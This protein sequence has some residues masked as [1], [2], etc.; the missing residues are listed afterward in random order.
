MILESTADLKKYVSVA[1]SFQ[2]PDIEPFIKKAA[3]QFTRPYVGELHVELK[4]EATGTDADL[5]NNARNHLR[6]ALTNF[7]FFLYS[8]YEAVLQDSS[9]ISVAKNQNQEPAAW[10]QLKDIR[11][12]RLLSGHRAMDF[13]L[14]ILEQNPDKFSSFTEAYQTINKELLVNTTDVFDRYYKIHQS[15]QT[16]LALMPSMRQVEDQFIHT[17]LCAELIA[18][19]KNQNPT[20]DVKTLKTLLQKAIVAF[21]VAKVA[22]EGIFTIDATG[23]RLNYE[24]MVS[25]NTKPVESNFTQNQ[26]ESLIKNQTNNGIQYL[27]MAKDLILAN[28]STFTQC[29]GNPIISRDGA[30]SGMTTYNTK[31]IFGL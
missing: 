4:D 9:G 24:S 26:V 22:R 19:L 8:P 20:G 1:D 30:G 6:D 31:G 15:R 12:E 13:L 10:W 14:V 21:T 5:K 27:G 29:N 25:F 2:F 16:F 23:I 18:A 3:D 11:R 17:F 28:P 7:A